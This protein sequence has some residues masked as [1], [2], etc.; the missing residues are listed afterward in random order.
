MNKG[1]KDRVA[2]VTGAGG[3]LGRSHAL[4]LARLGAKV[5]VNDLGSRETDGTVGNT[6]IDAVVEEIRAS[7]G[8][9][10]ALA[11][12]VSSLEQVN[13]MVAKAHETFGRVDILVNN[14]GILRDKSFAKTDPNDFALVL[15]VHLTGSFNCTHAV[16]KI[17]Q[18]Q[19]HGRVIFTSSGS[20]LYG[21]FGQA[22]YSAAKMAMIGL[23]NTL[24]IE[25]Q[26]Y[27]I[28]VNCL[29][30]TAA[31]RMTRDLMTPELAELLTP[32]SVTPAVLYLASSQAP[33]RMILCA[34]AGVYSVARIVEGPGDFLP[35]AERTVEAITAAINRIGDVSAP[36]GYDDA[37]QQMRTYA[38]LAAQEV[39]N[40][41]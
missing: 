4:G 11:A 37:F 27:G 38:M 20:G 36:R 34:G 7:G 40:R 35:E 17:M 1:F 9:A 16:W 25:G 10:I 29:V 30:P 31:T 14:A 2:I 19:N 41:G 39:G 33:S 18:A 5:V 28:K 32:E 6:A 8:T 3:G 21:N 22:A 26:R 13:A 24:H 15:N 12:D 23:M